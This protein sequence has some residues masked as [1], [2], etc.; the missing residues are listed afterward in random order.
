[1]QRTNNILTRTG[2]VPTTENV[3]ASHFSLLIHFMD[4]EEGSGTTNDLLKDS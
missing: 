1:M 4:E 3:E 2:Y